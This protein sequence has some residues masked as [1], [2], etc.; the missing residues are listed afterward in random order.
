MVQTMLGEKFAQQ[1]LN[2][3]PSN[4][5]VSRRLSDISEDLEEQLMEKLRN[6][7]LEYRW[8]RRLI[9]LVLLTL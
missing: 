3:P 1:L 2:I 7:R 8:T 5:T 6:N 4:N 9:V